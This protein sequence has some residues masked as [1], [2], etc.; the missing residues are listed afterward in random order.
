MGFT[1]AMGTAQ[2]GVNALRIHEIPYH[3]RHT[4]Q[5]LDL[6]VY[7]ELSPGRCRPYPGLALGDTLMVLGLIRNQGRP[8][9][10]HLDPGPARELVEGH[11]LVKE[12]VSPSGPPPGIDVIHIPVKRSGRQAAWTSR[13]VYRLSIPVCPVHEV[14]ANPV[15]AHSLHHGLANL[16]DRPSVFVDPARPPALKELLSRRKP[17]LILYPFNPGREDNFWQDSQWWIGLARAA[18]ERFSLVAVGA[19]DYGE[20]TGEVDACLTMDDPASTLAD[21]AWLFGRAAAFAGRDGGPSHLAAA[22]NPRVLVVWDSMAS[23]RFWA[24]R[25][26]NHV[27]LSNPYI[28]RYPQTCWLSRTELMERVARMRPSEGAGGAPEVPWTEQEFESLAENTFG[29]MANL[30]S[31]V[32]ALVEI[33]E[34][35]QGVRAWLEQTDIKQQY[36]IDSQA[37]AL[38]SLLGEAPPGESWVAPV[39][40]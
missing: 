5:R 23:Y 6:P 37:F 31:A 21:L 22:V 14:R 20:L 28:F 32:L 34:E 16:D 35:R 3:L 19:R 24:G 30:T 38:R 26:L 33:E 9:T 10:L 7:I 15:L 18:R 2:R 11:P 4:V 25:S 36:Y 29:G 40:P 39:F 1:V 13:L 27:L 12:L 17:T 8:I